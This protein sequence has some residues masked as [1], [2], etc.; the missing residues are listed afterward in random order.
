MEF[1]GYGSGVGSVSGIDIGA[2][3]LDGVE[4]SELE[5]CDCWIGWVFEEE[6]LTVASVLENGFRWVSFCLF[7]WRVVWEVESGFSIFLHIRLF[8]FPFSQSVVA[9]SSMWELDSSEVVGRAIGDG[10]G[11]GNGNVE[12][13]DY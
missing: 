8:S 9:L 1:T 6:G 11:N 3:F 7:G 4:V 5:V 12:G 13:R 10:G 2:D